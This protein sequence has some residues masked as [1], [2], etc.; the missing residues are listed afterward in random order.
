MNTSKTKNL[1]RIASAMLLA[2]AMNGCGDAKETN[3]VPA[4]KTSTPTNDATAVTCA[5]TATHMPAASTTNAAAAGTASATNAAKQAQET[6]KPKPKLEPAP[7]PLALREPEITGFTVNGVKSFDIGINHPPDMTSFME[8]V[9]IKPNPGPATADSWGDKVRIEADFKP[10]TKYQVIIKAGMPTFHGKLKNEFR[11]SFTTGDLPQSMD[12]ASSGRYLPSTGRRAIMVNSVNVTNIVCEIRPVPRGNIVQLLAREEDRYRSYYGGGGDSDDTKDISGA[13][14][15]KEFKIRASENEKVSTAIDIRDEEGVSANGVYLVSVRGDRQYPCYRLVCLTDI[16]LSVRETRGC[17]YVWATSLAK[18]TPMKDLLVTVYGANNVRVGEGI[19]DSDGWC[20]CEV[21][22]NAD[23]FAVVASNRNGSDMSFLAL[24]KCLDETI[25]RG[26]R[27][28]YVANGR[29]EAF[30]WTDRG[31]YRHNEKILVHALLRDAKGNAPTPFPVTLKLIDPDGKTFASETKVPDRQGALAVDAFA[32]TDDQKSGWWTVEAHTPGEKGFRLGSRHIKIEEFVPP[33]IRVKVEAPDGISATNISF[34]V[35]SEHLFGG[36]AKGFPAEG[37]VMFEDAP[38][39]PKGWEKFRFGDAERKLSP[40]FNVLGKRPLDEA[41]R[42][43]FTAAMPERSRPR[44]AVKMTAQGT[45]FEN[46]GRPASAR[47]TAILHFY[48]YYIGVEMPNTFRRDTRPQPCRVAL[49]NPDGTAR[50]GTRTL[51]ARFERIEHV[52]GLR[53][54]DNGH[55]EW[56]CDKIRYPMGEPVEIAVASNGVATLDVPRSILGDYA[57]TLQDAGDGVSFGASFWVGDADGDGEIR[58]PLENPSRVTLVADKPLY[59]PGDVPRIT[60]KSPFKGAAWIEVMQEDL[61]YSQIVSLTNATSEIALEPVTADWAPGVDVAISVV[62]AAK[63][64]Q[65]HTVNRAWGVTAL[66]AATRDSA[67]DVRVTADVRHNAAGG[68]S[69]L[70]AHVSALGLDGVKGD[71][72]AVTV[73]DEGI[74]IL[75]DEKTPDP[76]G[77]FGA[78]RNGHHPLYDI[79]NDLLPIVGDELKRSGVKTGGGADGD[80]FRRISPVPSRRFKPLSR[81]TLNVLLKDGKADVPFKLPEFAGEVRVTAVAYNS[82]ATGAGS[83]QKKVA[84]NLVMQAD[85]PRFAAPGD[86]FNATLML[87]NRSGKNGT[88][89]YS[90]RVDGA[91]ALAPRAVAD[92]KVELA[93]GA[94]ETLAIPIAANVPGEGRLVFVSEGLGERHEVVIDLPVRPAAAWVKTAQTVCLAAGESHTFK[95]TAEVMPE[96]AHRTFS[97]SSSAIGELASAFEYLS[98]Y[99][100]G[101]LEQTVSRV[102]PLVAAGGVLNLLPTAET[103]VAA[104]SQRTV[105]A[106]IRR[107]LSMIHSNDFSMWPD[108]DDPPWNPSVSL[109][110]A[111][112]L[113]EAETAGFKISSEPL[114]RVKGFMRKWA[115]STNATTSVYAC[116]NLALA[117]AP[118]L[119]RQLHW[120]DRRDK[121]STLDRARLAR[122]FVR[123]GDR[124]VELTSVL[125]VEDVK[126]ASFALLALMDIDPKDARLPGFALYLTKQRE[127]VSAH[128]GTTESNAHALLALGTWYRAHA[129]A[130]EAVVKMV[131]DGKEETLSTKKVRE[132]RGGGDITLANTGKGLAYVTAACLALPD[133]ANLPPLANGIEI[134][135]SYLLPD[136]KPA[137]LDNLSR[138]DLLIVKVDIGAKWKYVY[139]DLVVEDLL[140]ACFESDS[141]RIDSSR[142]PWIADEKDTHWEMRREMRD[143]RMLLFSSRF[144]NSYCIAPSYYAVRVV[145]NGDFVHPGIS[146]EA[147]YDPAVRARTSA[148]RIRVK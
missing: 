119:D 110:A 143:D 146:V 142:F 44:A 10:R 20:S 47:T 105:D 94:S 77:W 53:R 41:G 66:K 4:A 7:I 16:G 74:N 99:P 108:C 145:S 64:S 134:E 85:A 69:D 109:W 36:P 95:N 84:P 19:T 59:R 126:S 144:D 67:L 60:V 89:S 68:G 129:A 103:S 13:P 102:F 51:K 97:V 15:K 2:L 112:F 120:F 107:V 101:C 61:V 12:F 32:V 139:S 138:G 123:S 55:F 73:V 58:A 29:S 125:P 34:T 40:N 48:P 121:L 38:F 5:A 42:A 27:R 127:T 128:W 52:Y 76:A 63:P 14:V 133:A 6:Q 72:A 50:T 147:M 117:R 116:H 28:N 62:Q 30:V 1:A 124:A 75:T 31:I 56:M 140:P 98:S 81:W 33:Q 24:S 23:K 141:T 104:D 96:V 118:D 79:F 90:L 148:R 78:T 37:A 111:Q 86:K 137:D 132:V 122:A 92:G 80:L 45:V 65:R 46:G 131:A 39:A 87:S 82:R 26:K 91:T 70:V 106:G 57:V 17:V 21:D 9:V 135:R 22:A 115:M 93:D 35:S 88:A 8:Y 3:V 113:V 11:R 130:G 49:V 114:E 18:G 54:N 100:Y 43:V 83:V 71:F 25:E 136:G